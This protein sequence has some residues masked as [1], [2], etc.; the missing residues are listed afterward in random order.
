MVVVITILPVLVAIPFHVTN[1]F[2]RARAEQNQAILQSSRAL[3]LA[4]DRDLLVTQK[5]LELLAGS[6]SLAK[7]DLEHIYRRGSDLVKIGVGHNVV[8]CDETGQQLI[9]TIRP[10]GE[11]LPRHGNMAHLRR[12][13][14][15]GQP[16]IADLYIGGVLHRPLFSIDVPVTRDGKVVYALA[17]GILPENLG[18]IFVEQHLPPG[19][20]AAIID[21]SGTIVARTAQSEK[22]VGHK[23]AAPLLKMLQV[24]SEGTLEAETLENIP[25]YA[26]Y[27]RSAATGWTVAIA[28][29]RATLLGEI[30]EYLLVLGSGAIFLL[31]LGVILGARVAQRIARSINAL[32]PATLA[33]GEGRPMAMPSTEIAEVALVSEALIGVEAQLNSHRM[34]LEEL[35]ANR[36]MELRTIIETEPECV[37]QLAE[38]GTL[39]Q[40]NRAGLDMIEAETLEQVAGQKVQQLIVPEYREA[41]DVLTR[42]VF[43]GKSGTLV[44]EIQGL[45]GGRRWLETHAVPLRDSHGQITALLGVTRDVTE[46]KRLEDQI[47]QLAFH[48]PLTQLPNRR[49]FYDRLNQVMAT[50]RR[51][52]CYGAVMFLDLD[53]FKPLNDMHGHEVGDLLLIEV[54]D[55]LKH[56]VRETDTVGRFGGDE[57]VVMLSELNSSKD[58]STTQARIVA[59]KIRKTLAEPYRLTIRQDGKDD[60]VIEHRCTASIGVVL[61]IEHEASQDEIL[62]WADAAMYQ[63]KD[64]GRNSIQFHHSED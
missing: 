18:K 41:F 42:Q 13:F 58:A 15:S 9:N 20:I 48:D 60:A 53:N 3:M 36:T 33:L 63:A 12:V 30:R 14:E 11:P 2:E 21:R 23:A 39:L 50:T 32:V 22:F 19:Y 34:Q 44:F 56:C 64:A 49:L 28:V 25:S 24:S 10:F 54:A 45:K 29:P 57:F 47:H 6:Q 8:L 40:M 16:V 26:A 43:A 35:V 61:F 62:R 52:S 7:G 4:V 31:I 46:R 55:R 37:K 51:S 38:D 1:L 17:A 27:T 59:E 5:T